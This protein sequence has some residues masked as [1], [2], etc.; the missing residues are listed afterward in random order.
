MMRLADVRRCSKVS[1]LMLVVT[2][3]A[4]GGCSSA[5]SYGD[6]DDGRPRRSQD[7]IT[8]EEIM[9]RPD[10]D[11]YSIIQQLRPAW[12]RMRPASS[13][14]DADASQP[15]V[16]LDTSPFGPID[17]LYQIESTQIERMEFVSALDATTLYGTGYVGG[18]IRVV[19]KRG[20]Q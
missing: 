5:T 13:F 2:L 20:R 16:F 9:Q 17:S 12:L 18:I 4:L 8:S 1:A 15:Y 19:T 10:A 3:S 7:L 14:L 11:A 6:Q